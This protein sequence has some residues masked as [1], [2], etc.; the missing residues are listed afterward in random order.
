[1]TLVFL[2]SLGERS[3]A[4]VL[5]AIGRAASLVP[6]RLDRR[7]YWPGPRVL[8][9]AA[10]VAPDFDRLVTGLRERLMAA[11]FAVDAKPFQAHVTL[12]R[13]V[14]PPASSDEPLAAPISWQPTGIHLMA[15]LVETAGRP[16][17]TPRYMVR[18][19]VAFGPP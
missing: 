12:A 10:S 15:S 3:E 13:K 4:E 14:R 1:M 9:A 7:A 18:G 11:G 2:G 16:A 8:C 17:G 19:V 5:Q 6:V